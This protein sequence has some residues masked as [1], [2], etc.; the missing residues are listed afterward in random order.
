[1]GMNRKRQRQTQ[2]TFCF[3]ASNAVNLGVLR[4]QTQRFSIRADANILAVIQRQLLVFWQLHPPRPAPQYLGSFK[5]SDGDSA[6]SQRNR[7]R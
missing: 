2:K 1:M 6:L 7:R 3:V 4:N 5:Y